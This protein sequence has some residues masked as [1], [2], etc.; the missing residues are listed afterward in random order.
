MVN[1]KNYDFA[2][3]A[4]KNN[5]LCADG[6]TIRR[7]A[8]K[9]CDGKV[10]PLVWNHGGRTDPTEVLGHALL[11][12]RDD[13]VYM[14]G[15]FNNTEK[16]QVA[17]ECVKNGDITGLSI[18]ANSLKQKAGDVLHGVIREV[19]LVLS[20]A[21]P[22]ATIDFVM[23]HNSD[24][25]DSFYYYLNGSD[26]CELTHSDDSE[27]SNDYDE[28]EDDEVYDEYD[29]EIEHADEKM[30]DD[31]K[32]NEVLKVL[33]TLSDEQKAAV[34]VLIDSITGKSVP[35]EEKKEPEVKHAD[36]E[37]DSKKDDKEDENEDGIPADKILETL[38]DKQKAAVAMMIEAV[39][40][41]VKENKKKDDT[42]SE[43]DEKDEEDD[44]K[45]NA[46]DEG[47]TTYGDITGLMRTA[48]AD[49]ERYGSLKKS[50]IA[51]AEEFGYDNDTLAHAY[52]TD[53]GGNTITYGVSNIGYMYP[54][55]Q[56]INAE[57][58]FIKR[59]TEWVAE[60][61]NN[62]HK[63]PFSRVKSIF[64]NI[65][66]DEARAKGYVKGSLKAEEV[67]VLL[68]RVTN[69]YTIFKKQ[70]LDRD[71]ILDI[72]KNFQ[73]VPWMRKELEIM[74]DEEKARAALVGDGRSNASSDK[75]PELNIRPIYTDDDL[76]SIKATVEVPSD[77]NDDDDAK[78]LIRTAIKARKD[79][80]GSGN[81]IMF[82]TPDMLAN[83]L[84]LEDGLGRSLYATEAELATK[85]RVKKIVECPVMENL[86]RTSGTGASAKTLNLGAI[87]V[88]PYDYNFGTDTN[89]QN[90]FFQDFDI[91]YNQEKYL[92][93][94]RTSGALVVPYSA[95]VVEF[96]P[97]GDPAHTAASGGN[98]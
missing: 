37:P 93:E 17:K 90:T 89:G 66:A 80:R 27:D 10:V 44:M 51:H 53:D 38:N 58:G 91:D 43:D 56:A 72:A 9:S 24:S 22:G 87:I 78:A 97:S 6:R 73:I 62:A 57:P 4:T 35:S 81:P 54:D 67:I 20:G 34:V 41:E 14:Y 83:M 82:T 85:L 36:P 92:L 29:D 23:Q 31:I 48:V 63:T 88:N 50:I 11:E 39:V 2:G 13:G 26:Y 75:I 59:P 30:T 77:H 69:P 46:F 32:E 95:I 79:Y 60:F 68:K 52:P 21:N 1:A 19:S 18:Y 61:L 65:T 16:A 40:D 45:H 98:G 5:L 74:L 84:L 12:N 55:A 71:D 96:D 76:Y 28:Y 15:T 42:D 49:L 70:K 86:T 64:A 8:F 25:L 47:T 7:N 33:N 94:T 3:Y